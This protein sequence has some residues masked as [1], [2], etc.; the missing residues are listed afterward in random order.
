[1]CI[2]V[3]REEVRDDSNRDRVNDVEDTSKIGARVV[4]GVGGGFVVFGLRNVDF[5][6]VIGYRRLL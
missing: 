4:C 6:D 2:V 1:M 3:I 5:G